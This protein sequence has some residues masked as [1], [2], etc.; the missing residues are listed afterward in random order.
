MG[1][2]TFE[3]PAATLAITAADRKVPRALEPLAETADVDE[4]AETSMIV[5]G[6]HS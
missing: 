2:D 1:V 3:T 4:L 5:G 6:G